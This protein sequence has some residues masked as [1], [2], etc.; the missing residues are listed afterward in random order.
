[1]S[2]FNEY[3]SYEKLVKLALK[4]FDLSKNGALTPKRLS[5]FQAES[6]NL[7][8]FYGTERI[9]TATIVGLLTRKNSPLRLDSLRLS[10]IF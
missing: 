6:L 9:Y 10:V 2:A 1:M 3:R 4:P 5:E 7:K 8:L